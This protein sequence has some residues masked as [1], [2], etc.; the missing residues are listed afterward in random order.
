MAFPKPTPPVL[1]SLETFLATEKLLSAAR[2]VELLRYM[3]EEELTAG[4][5]VMRLQ[6]VKPELLSQRLERA[7]SI[8][9]V[10]SASLAGVKMRKVL[11]ED[12]IKAWQVV[13]VDFLDESGTR[14]LLLGMTD[15]LHRAILQSAEGLARLPIQPA[16]LSWD[17]Y[18][19]VC[20]SW[21]PG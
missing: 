18:V 21:F 3:A 6:W 9:T 4:S 11:T 7:F 2:S 19:K 16:F 15:P 10:T 20:E 14:K 1:P 13:P 12:K 8:P 17:E 5:A